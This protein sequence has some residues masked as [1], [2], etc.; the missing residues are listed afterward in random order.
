M[1]K[2]QLFTQ[3]WLSQEL[4]TLVA[5]RDRFLKFGAESVTVG[6]TLCDNSNK[7]CENSL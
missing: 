5:F 3:E 6:G 2:L 4:V 1:N 7:V